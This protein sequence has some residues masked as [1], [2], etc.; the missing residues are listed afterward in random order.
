MDWTE[1]EYKQNKRDKVNERSLFLQKSRDEVQNIDVNY[2]NVKDQIDEMP[3]HDKPH[4]V[5]VFVYQY[6]EEIKEKPETE[7]KESL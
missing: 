6:E 5:V 3:D 2:Y 7:M 1:K 4:R